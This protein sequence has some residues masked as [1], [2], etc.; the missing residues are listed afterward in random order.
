[1]AAAVATVDTL[2]AVLGKVGVTSN[3]SLCISEY[4]MFSTMLALTRLT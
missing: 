1:M 3:S 4:P 2:A